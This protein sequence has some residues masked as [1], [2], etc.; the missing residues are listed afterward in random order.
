M[1]N[2]IALW[3]LLTIFI[4]LAALT[5]LTGQQPAAELETMMATDEPEA[6]PEPTFASGSLLRIFP[7]LRVLDI[8][9][10]RLQDLTSGKQLTLSRAADGTWIAP[11]LE[12]TLDE[13]A[14]SNIARTLVLLPYARS[15]NILPGTEFEVYDLAPT[16]R[17]LFQILKNNGESHVVA[18]GSLIDSGAAY[19]T[20]VDER[21]EIFQTERGA[22]DFLK[23]QIDTP[24]TRL[25]N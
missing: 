17:L 8:H 14:A 13:T 12:G 21:D 3:V 24:P 19:Y 18:V 22:V 6:T 20:L 10:I 25:T 2:R 16:P 4:V 5:A 9:A 23:N 11:D 1:R 15:I 7:D